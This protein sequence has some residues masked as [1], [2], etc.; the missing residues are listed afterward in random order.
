M[1][2]LAPE[3]G[4]S[5]MQSKDLKVTIS[6]LR[7]LAGRSDIEPRQKQLL[8]K[9]IERLKGYRRRQNPGKAEAYRCVRDVAQDLIEAFLV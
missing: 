6:R 5:T 1:A 3:R 9:A 4:E 8:E 2:Q 7:E